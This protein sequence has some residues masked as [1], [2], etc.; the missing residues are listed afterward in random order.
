MIEK[1]DLVRLTDDVDS[2]SARFCVGKKLTGR[3]AACDKLAGRTYF[4][5][6]F[7]LGYWVYVEDCR[8]QLVAK[9]NEFPMLPGVD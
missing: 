7:G 9:S 1:N 8:V 2:E 3:V 6:D 4:A 5:I